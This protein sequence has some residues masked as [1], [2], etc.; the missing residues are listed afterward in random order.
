MSKETK[1]R[2]VE[3]QATPTVFVRAENPKDAATTNSRYVRSQTNAIV[4]C[5]FVGTVVGILTRL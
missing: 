4:F 5:C 2:D 3:A 1:T